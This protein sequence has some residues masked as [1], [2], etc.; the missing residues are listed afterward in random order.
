MIKIL[1]VKIVGCVRGDAWC[2]NAVS[3]NAACMWCVDGE[4]YGLE[5]VVGDAWTVW[6][7]G[8]D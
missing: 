3:F 8:W 6:Y 2:G 4:V 5:L 7:I 1:G